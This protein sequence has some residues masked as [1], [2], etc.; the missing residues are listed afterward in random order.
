[1]YRMKRLPLPPKI[2]WT[3]FIAVW[4]PVY[5]QHYGPQNFLWLCDLANFLICLALWFESPL[6][7]SSQAV[8]IILIQSLWIVDVLGRVVTGVHLIGGTE[9]MFNS[10]IPVGVRLFSMFHVIT[11]LLALWAI[12][13][14]GYDR[15]G[16]IIQTGIAW[17]ILPV[18]FLFTDPYRDINWVWGLFGKQ[19]D[20]L[21]PYLF[22]IL[23]MIGY[24]LIIYLPTHLLLKRLF[25]KKIIH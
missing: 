24:P 5:W 22:F 6:I 20:H 14:L 17:I 21:H 7:L 16:W 15:R 18:S 23:L 8:S 2:A 12:R 1:M 4:T 13:R 19:Q 11:P 9:Y 3:V 25:I 10:A